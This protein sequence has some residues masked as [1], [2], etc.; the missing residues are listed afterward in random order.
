MAPAIITKKGRKE[1]YRALQKAQLEDNYEPILE[2][3]LNAVLRG[4]RIIGS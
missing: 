2:Y 1:Y 3:I 4:Y